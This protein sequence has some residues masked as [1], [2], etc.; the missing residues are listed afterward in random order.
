MLRQEKYTILVSNRKTRRGQYNVKLNK[1]ETLLD[2]K[3][4]RIDV[5]QL[6]GKVKINIEENELQRNA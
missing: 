2:K 1:S 6:K 3:Q 4:R 5:W